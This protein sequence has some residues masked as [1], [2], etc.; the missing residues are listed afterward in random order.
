MSYTS[1]QF[2]L[3]SYHLQPTDLW[4]TSTSGFL[5]TCHPWSCVRS[6]GFFI[7]SW[8]VGKDVFS[9]CSSA[10]LEFGVVVSLSAFKY[11]SLLSFQDKAPEIICT[12]LCRD[13]EHQVRGL[14][15]LQGILLSRIIP[16]GVI[17]GG[18][19]EKS[20][21]VKTSLIVGNFITTSYLLTIYSNVPGGQLLLTKAGNGT[22]FSTLLKSSHP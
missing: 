7:C 12:N 2:Q 22:C 6:S 19:Q 11:F 17:P 14:H 4:L 18:A 8:S 3:C 9:H 21:Q 13:G 5:A 15:I 1:H 10:S 20:A 16:R